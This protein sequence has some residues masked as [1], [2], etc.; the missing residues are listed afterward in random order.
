MA[1]KSRA[2][3]RRLFR[4]LGSL[5]RFLFR[6]QLLTIFLALCVLGFVIG[7]Q[8][9]PDPRAVPFGELFREMSVVSYRE[10]PSDTTARFQIELAAGGKVFSRYD[11]DAGR[12]L[13]PARERE[14]NRAITGTVYRPL[15]VRGHVASGLWLDVPQR[16][17]AAPLGEQFV[18]LYRAT[19]DFVKPVSLVG[20][21]LGTLSGYS[22]GYRLGIWNTSLRSRAVQERVLATPEL[23]RTIAREAWYLVRGTYRLYQLRI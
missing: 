20:G 1:R 5:A 11:I 13:P 12:F 21:A 15:Q 16:A 7:I 3:V 2:H 23:G 14:Y 19:L 8:T 6:S 22:V 4:S 17:G 18:E 10:S 9:R